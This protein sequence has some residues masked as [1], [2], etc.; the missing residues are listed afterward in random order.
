[1]IVQTLNEGDYQQCSAFAELMLRIIEEHEDAIIMMSDEAHFQFSKQTE[2][3]ILGP[4][5]SP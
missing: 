2:L 4:T 3:P 1:M 5:K